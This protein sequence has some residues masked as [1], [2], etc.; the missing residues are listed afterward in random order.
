[1]LTGTLGMKFEIRKLENTLDNSN[2]IQRLLEKRERERG[3]NRRW[4]DECRMIVAAGCKGS[5]IKRRVDDHH[6]SDEGNDGDGDH[7]VMVQ[8]DEVDAKAE[9]FNKKFKQ[10]LRLEK[11]KY[12]EEYYAMLARGT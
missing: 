3:E 4:G 12:V 11:Q 8:M 9:E 2:R 6:D 10:V 1:M 7:A 5:M